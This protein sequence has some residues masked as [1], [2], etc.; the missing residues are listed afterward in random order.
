MK[1]CWA[2]ILFRSWTSMAIPAVLLVSVIILFEMTPLD[3]IIQDL[4]YIGDGRWCI[5][6]HKYSGWGLFYY[7]LPKILLGMFGAAVL[8][9]GGWLF[10]R[11]RIKPFGHIYVLVC[12]GAIPGVVAILKANSNMPYPRKLVQ[13][14]GACQKVSLADAYLKPLAQG[15]KQYKGWPGGHASGG[16]AIM[17]LAFVFTAPRKRW[18]GFLAA[19]LLGFFM[20][21][22]HTMDGNHFISHVLV[23]FFIGWL[24]SALLYGLYARYVPCKAKS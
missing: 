3:D 19:V 8:F 21:M 1:R 22:G 20:G 12:L 17:G 5:E 14:G 24:V 4:F 15:E 18:R 23:S 10:F 7:T 2:D 16:F 6:F 11:K 13:Y 9:H